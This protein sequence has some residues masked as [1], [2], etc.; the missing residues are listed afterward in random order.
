MAASG[1][2]E[3]PA[4]ARD[5]VASV[6]LSAE[7]IQAA[8]ARIGAGISHDYVGRDPVLVAVLKGSAP[9]I[10]DLLRAID[11]PVSVDFIAISSYGPSARNSGV[12]RLLKDLDQPIEGRHVLV[13]E[14]IID[15]G[16]TLHYILRTLRLRRPAT[17]EVG[18]LFNKPARRLVNIPLRYVGFDLPDRFVVG[19]GLDYHERYRNLPF[20]CVLKPEVYGG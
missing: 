2:E 11:I 20:L 12:V 9:L 19:Y 5:H 8:I 3:I 7:E 15:T 10:A 16:L 14:D 6:L 13:I 17:L 18:T 4:F 1:P